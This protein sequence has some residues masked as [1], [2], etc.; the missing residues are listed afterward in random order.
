LEIIGVF[1]D[2]EDIAVIVLRGLPSKFAAIK[3]VIRAQFV[4]Y[5]MGELTSDLVVSYWRLILNMR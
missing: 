5:T 3:T 4:S 1:M 2:D